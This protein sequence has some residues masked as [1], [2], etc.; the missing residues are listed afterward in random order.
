MKHQLISSAQMYAT[1]CS[2][3]QTPSLFIGC[4][5]NM[6]NDSE[7]SVTVGFWHFTRRDFWEL[8]RWFG[9]K[10][11]TLLVVYSCM[12]GNVNNIALGGLKKRDAQLERSG[13]NWAS[14]HC[15]T[16]CSFFQSWW[17]LVCDMTPTHR[18]FGGLLFLLSEKLA[19]ER[20]S[21][22]R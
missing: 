17:P 15:G 4:D 16:C 5:I 3:G 8:H 6:N 2:C 7:N 20:K 14:Y 22:S 19:N 12:F 9:F 21:S 18:G 10:T 1:V 11:H 13:E